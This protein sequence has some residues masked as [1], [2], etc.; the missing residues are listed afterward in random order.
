M[1]NSLILLIVTAFLGSFLLIGTPA[2]AAPSLSPTDTIKQAV[3]EVMN[4]MKQ[5]GITDPAVRPSL[6]KKIQNL[7]QNMFD[8]EEFSA[9]TVGPQWRNFTPEQ[10]KRFNTAFADLLRALYIEKLEGYNG[11]QVEYTGEIK[12]TKGDKAEVQTSILIKDKRVPVSYR[13]LVKGDVWRVYDVLIE[14]M[15]LVEN[16]RGQF[17]DIIAKGNPEQLIQRVEAKAEEIRKQNASG[18]PTKE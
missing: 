13:M 8:F 17:R 3:N 14:Q 9:R 7:V 1:K 5:P 6:L 4:I 10:K 11:E 16:Y 15:S 2:Q 18:L 12:S